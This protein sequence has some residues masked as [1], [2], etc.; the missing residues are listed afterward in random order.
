MSEKL[1]ALREE[2]KKRGLEAYL[3]TG[4][5]PHL[6]EYVA[7]HYRSRHWLSGFSGSAGTLIITQNHAGLWTDFRYWIQAEKELEKS[8]VSLFKEGKPETP[9]KEEWL[10]EQLS[11]GDALG[12]N[13]WELSVQEGARWASILAEKGISLMET[14]DLLQDIWTDRPALCAE[15][16]QDHPIEYAGKSREQKITQLQEVLTLHQKDAYLVTSLDELAWLLNIRGNDIPHNPVVRGYAW[17]EKKRVLLFL[18]TKRLSSEMKTALSQPDWEIREY[19]DILEWINEQVRGSLWLNGDKTPWL[20]LHHLSEDVRL[21]YQPSPVV[22]AKSLKNTS[23]LEGFR[24]IMPRDGAALVR[25]QRWLLKQHKQKKNEITE[26]D[27]ALKI[28]QLRSEQKHYRMDSFAPISAF[29]ENGAL[30]H[31]EPSADKP[32]PLT[33]GLYL[34]DSGGQYLEGTT[35]ITRTFVLGAATEQQRKDYTL[36]LKGHLAVSMALFPK[37]TRGYQL[38]TLAR[39]PLWREELDYGHGT[40][41]GVGSYLNVHEGPQSLSFKPIDQELLPGMVISNEP[42]IYREGKHGIRIENLIAVKERS[43]GNFLDFETLTWYPYEQELINLEMLSSEEIHWIDQ[44]HQQVFQALSPLL[45]NDERT[46]LKERCN[47]LG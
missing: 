34:L 43:T 16:I 41:H 22:L 39:Y 5:D 42:G 2:M 26:W 12:V 13:G 40:G 47:K 31:Y 21:F 1:T 23:E 35:D 14:G 37:G 45:N 8:D 4:S 24:T 29:S 33:E 28:S 17:I 27:A 46:W 30:C 20:F 11:E 36:V 19:E 6:S 32:V 25:F 3:I 9:S 38:D 44:Y 18:E 10:G 7:S 15:S